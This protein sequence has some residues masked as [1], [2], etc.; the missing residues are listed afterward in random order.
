MPD[1]KSSGAG[2]LMFLAIILIWILLRFMAGVVDNHSAKI[3][4]LEQRVEQ[5]ES[6]RK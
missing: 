2:W 1:N 4:D 6:E 5:L 3:H